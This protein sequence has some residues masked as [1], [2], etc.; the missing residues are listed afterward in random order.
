MDGL[1]PGNEIYI[2]SIN[3]VTFFV[4]V[5]Y[6][7]FIFLSVGGCIFFIHSSINCINES[8]QLNG[9]LTKIEMKNILRNPS[10][11][12]LEVIGILKNKYY[13][14]SIRDNGIEKKSILYYPNRI[15]KSI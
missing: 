5:R 2:H 7:R 14:V 12:Q 15:S 4:L 8:Q 13:V 11:I 1:L 6:K 9:Y 3:L 10:E